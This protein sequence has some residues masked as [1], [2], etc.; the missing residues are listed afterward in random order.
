MTPPIHPNATLQARVKRARVYLRGETAPLVDTAAIAC[1]LD[2]VS[3]MLDAVELMRYAVNEILGYV[4]GCDG[5]EHLREAIYELRS[6]LDRLL[7]TAAAPPVCGDG[8][9]SPTMPLT[10]GD[11]VSR[12]GVQDDQTSANPATS[13]G[14]QSRPSGDAL[15]EGGGS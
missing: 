5:D 12:E 11:P 14:G 2:D 10:A 9:Q 13:P 6:G 7:G 3:E 15:G 4:G 8:A 1:L